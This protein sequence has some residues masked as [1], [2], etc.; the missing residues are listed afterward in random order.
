MKTKR[1]PNKADWFMGELMV[2]V[3]K[4]PNDE[5]VLAIVRKAL[6]DLDELVAKVRSDLERGD[7]AE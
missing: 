7:H 4:H 5:R 3:R 2:W 6:A 1:L